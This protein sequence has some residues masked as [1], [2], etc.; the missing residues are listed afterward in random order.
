M[1]KAI[2][3][4]LPKYPTAAQ[5]KGLGGRVVVGIRIGAD[6]SVVDVS[7][8]SSTSPLFIDACL[9]AVKQFQFELTPCLIGKAPIFWLLTCNFTASH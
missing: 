8:I 5:A 2:H 9:A 3:R 1:P 6:G 4:G 7:V